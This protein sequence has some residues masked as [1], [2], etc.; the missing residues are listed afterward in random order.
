[1]DMIGKEFEELGEV[2]ERFS[3]KREF[4]G[5]ERLHYDCKTIKKIREGEVGKGE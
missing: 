4:E 2:Q 3:Q 1:M 5:I